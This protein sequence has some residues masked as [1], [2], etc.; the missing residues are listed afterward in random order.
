MKNDCVNLLVMNLAIADLLILV[1]S[2]PMDVVPEHISWPYGTFV[3]KFI[4][5]IQDI[6]LT[7]STLTFSVIA[8]ERYLV[9]RG[10][11]HHG[12]RNAKLV[13]LNVI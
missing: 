5:P 10:V 1:V 2:I 4:S 8:V 7:G 9:S 3:C 13:K 11:V 12:D 6:C